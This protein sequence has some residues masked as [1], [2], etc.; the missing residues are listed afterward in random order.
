[1]RFTQTQLFAEN[2]P[3]TAI[4]RQSF[5]N[6]YIANYTIDP[7]TYPKLKFETIEAYRLDGSSKLNKIPQSERYNEAKIKQ[8]SDERLM[9][10]LTNIGG[11][12]TQIN[13]NVICQKLHSE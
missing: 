3:F 5:T 10:Q 6:K 7:K 2:K 9:M 4:L 1:M 13:T 12:E 11:R 8:I